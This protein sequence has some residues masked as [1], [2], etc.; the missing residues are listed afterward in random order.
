MEAG[1]PFPGK[2][3]FSRIVA[4]SFSPFS[5]PLLTECGLRGEDRKSKASS[6]ELDL[7]REFDLPAE[8]LSSFRSSFL[9]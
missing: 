4:L 5:T 8:F 2:G 7:E 1:I 9:V 6:K 3:S